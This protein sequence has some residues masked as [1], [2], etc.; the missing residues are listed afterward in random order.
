MLRSP[1]GHDRCRST[2]DNRLGGLRQ[3]Q[4]RIDPAHT[5][6]WSKKDA[7]RVHGRTVN[8]SGRQFE[9]ISGLFTVG[10]L[11]VD[12]ID[13]AHVWPAAIDPREI[14]HSVV[15]GCH[16]DVIAAPR[17]ERSAILRWLCDEV[18]GVNVS[19]PVLLS[20]PM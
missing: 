11:Q 8:D 6:L 2:T 5:V 12:D 13:S 16:C 18:F 3:R 10:L 1:D 20:L 15:H 19:N 4:I 14:A 17:A 7:S 9:G